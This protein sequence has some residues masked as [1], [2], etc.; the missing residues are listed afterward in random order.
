MNKKNNSGSER[1]YP[2]P[3]LRIFKK[4]EGFSTIDAMIALAILAMV[5]TPIISLTLG[6]QSMSVDSETSH[7]ALLIAKRNMDVAKA[8]LRNDFYGTVSP[9]SNDVFYTPLDVDVTDIS[10]CSKNVKSWVN[11]RN[12]SRSQHSEVVSMI[13][14]PEES[15]MIGGNCDPLP[16]IGDWDAPKS[17]NIFGPNDFDGQGT[18]VDVS[19]ING[20][21]Y[22]F[23]TTDADKPGSD[24]FYIINAQDPAMAF[25]EAQLKIGDEGLN[26]LAVVG[27]YAY[28]LYTSEEN[29]LVV[30][31]I[32]NHDVVENGSNLGYTLPNVT[33]G[34]NPIPVSI[35]YYDQ[36]L[37]IGTE[38]LAFGNPGEN[39]ELHVFDLSTPA[40]PS[41]QSSINVDRRIN[42]IT[43]RGG[44]AYLA[45]GSGG[46]NTPLKIYDLS[47]GSMMS[48]FTNTNNWNGKSLYLLGTKLYFGLERQSTGNDPEFYVFDISNP[49]SPVES[50]VLD[51]FGPPSSAAITGVV[52]QGNL[53][54]LVTT[55]SNDERLYIMD[56]TKPGLPRVNTCSVPP[57]PQA[58]TGIVYMDDYLFV[59]IRSNEAF[60][61]I[62]PSLTCL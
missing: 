10:P 43:V 30:V 17:F 28:A 12:E 16:P 27:N 32:V 54:F 6:D 8:Q 19:F 2:S 11:W 26:G 5:F 45:T 59:S 44:V 55:D 46:D 18:G 41:W 57:L 4:G 25:I 14:S 21:R 37:Y 20:T 39:E 35:F 34:E 13:T 9:E 31:D 15:M 22:A 48:E 58:G 51:D 42:G 50:K 40:S 47:S 49:S 53:A 29:Q 7:A 52:V 61:I 23:L 33:P 56:I 38:Y 60:R 36:K 62:Y 3:F 24:N 1:I